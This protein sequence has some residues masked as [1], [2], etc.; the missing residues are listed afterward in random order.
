MKTWSKIATSAFIALVATTFDIAHRK[1]GG[2]GSAA[3]YYDPH[4]WEEIIDLAP[5]FFGIFLVFFI[6]ALIYFFL[7]RRPVK[8]LCS[9]CKY[10]IET[11]KLDK[12]YCYECDQKMEKEI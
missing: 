7:I 12:A 8:F 11:T 2:L 1:I 9:N 6:G 3:R 5:S 10:K 4:S